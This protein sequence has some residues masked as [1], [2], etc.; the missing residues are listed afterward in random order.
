MFV[1]SFHLAC[2]NFEILCNFMPQH[3]NSVSSWQGASDTQVYE[4]KMNGIFRSC[5]L[6]LE[7]EISRFV[8]HCIRIKQYFHGNTCK[9]NCMRAAVLMYDESVS[10]L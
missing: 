7:D 9:I 2:K 10:E 3:I 5:N 1:L 4:D 6:L 8:R